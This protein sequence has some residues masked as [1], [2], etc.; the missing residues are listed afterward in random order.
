MLVFG[1]YF[2]I[3]HNDVWLYAEYAGVYVKERV[4]SACIVE[5]LQFFVD[6]YKWVS[7]SHG[8]RAAISKESC[9]SKNRFKFILVFASGIEN[10]NGAWLMANNNGDPVLSGIRA[11]RS[12]NNR[13]N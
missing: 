9:E 2:K 13:G 12:I 10:F 3:L 7:E 4:D 11:P 6:M 8:A 5:L 1:L